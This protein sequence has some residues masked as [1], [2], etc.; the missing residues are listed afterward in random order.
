MP[1]NRTCSFFLDHELEF[2]SESHSAHKP[3]RIL[4]EAFIRIPNSPDASYRKVCPP[5]EWIHEFAPRGSHGVDAEVATSKIFVD[6][7]GETQ[8][9]RMAL[10]GIFSFDTERRHLNDCQCGIMGG[11][12]HADG[13]ETVLIRC[14]IGSPVTIARGPALGAGENRLNLL[15]FRIG[16]DI[17]IFR[18]TAQKQIA[19]ATS[20]RVRAM[21]ALRKSA[22][23]LRDLFRER[24]PFP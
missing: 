4:G 21:A 8:F 6:G 2:G 23:D 11:R 16:R 20:N 1:Q 19:H 15:G 5:A 9:V 18:R 12:L 13:A 24:E 3:Q 10:I 7:L 17:P 22:K 14:R